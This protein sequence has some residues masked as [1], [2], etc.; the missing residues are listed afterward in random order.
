MSHLRL[1]S[2]DIN[3]MHGHV[4]EHRSRIASQSRGAAFT[5]LSF[6]GPLKEEEK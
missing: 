1:Y 6:E 3:R 2:L 4:A 5:R